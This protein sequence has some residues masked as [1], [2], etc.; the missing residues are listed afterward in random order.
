MLWRQHVLPPKAV[1]LGGQEGTE[2]KE[3]GAH[4]AQASR[5]P[6]SYSRE[7]THLRDQP[8]PGPTRAFGMWISLSGAQKFPEA[9]SWGKVLSLWGE[10]PE[11]G[12]P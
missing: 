2:R 7:H 9:A 11:R 1:T 8:G 6:L 10:G 4:G 5:T 12:P 3:G